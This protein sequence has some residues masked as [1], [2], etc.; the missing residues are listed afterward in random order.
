MQA[1]AIAYPDDVTQ[2]G[3]LFLKNAT[4]NDDDMTRRVHPLTLELPMPSRSCCN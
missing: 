3:E 1:L 2:V 4:S